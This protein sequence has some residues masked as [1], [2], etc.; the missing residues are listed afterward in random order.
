MKVHSLIFTILFLCLAGLPLTSSAI[1]IEAGDIV[2][3]DF[4]LSGE[5]PAPPYEGIYTSMSF[6]SDTLDSG[7]GFS[8]GLFDDGGEGL[9]DGTGYYVLYDILGTFD[10]ADA[11]AKGRIYTGGIVTTPDVT[12]FISLV[13]GFPDPTASLA[14]IWDYEA[15]F[16]TDG[17]VRNIS[18]LG[19]D[20]ILLPQ[21]SVPEPS[22]LALM[23]AG[24]V[25][26]VFVRRRRI[27]A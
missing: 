6:G 20:R 13:V 21:S 18:W 8:L 10:L 5:T 27:K 14:S 4:D 16:N 17:S 3:V 12:G 22:I 23:G 1:L 24:L 26:L 2:R 9:T 15:G 19:H 25:G 7:E 11:W